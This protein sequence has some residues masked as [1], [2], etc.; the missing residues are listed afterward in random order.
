[1][2][3]KDDFWANVESEHD[4]SIPSMMI[5]DNQSSE[6]V[7]ITGMPQQIT[8][9]QHQMI[10]MQQPSSAPKV[11]GIFVIIWGALQ[12]LLT[13]SGPF[14]ND[15]I[16]G[17]TQVDTTMQWYDYLVSLISI[18]FGLGFIYAGYAISERQKLGVHLAW[19]LL[20]A[21][22]VVS[23]IVTIFGPMPEAPE[24]QEVNESAFIGIAIGG[25]LFCNAI[26]GLMAAIPLMANNTLM[27]PIKEEKTG[28]I[29]WSNEVLK[30]E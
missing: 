3:D 18:V 28:K 10:M 29:E 4:K 26:C 24:G 20:A 25:Q 6:S 23:I 16:S 8:G 19:G 13:I 30:N 15:A 5:S 12:I 27:E 1:M 14:I 22:L 9:T 7:M 2:E 11:I 17:A 21:G